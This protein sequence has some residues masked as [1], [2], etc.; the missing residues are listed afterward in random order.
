[1]KLPTDKE[2]DILRILASHPSGLYGLEL[3]ELSEGSVKR[4]SVYVYLSRLQK[5]KLV[6]SKKTPPPD[7]YGG[8]PRPVYSITGMGEKVLRAADTYKLSFSEAVS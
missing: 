8:L 6:K 5:G 2:L 4:G 3:V 1:M 7:G